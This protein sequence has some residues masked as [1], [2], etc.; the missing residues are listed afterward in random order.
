[1]ELELCIII[2]SMTFDIITMQIQDSEYILL[3]M[4]Q[5]VPKMTFGQK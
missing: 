4:Y 1:M 2:P 5:K 3:Y